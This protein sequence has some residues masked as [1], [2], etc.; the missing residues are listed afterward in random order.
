M[1]TY[2]YNA[3]NA[4]TASPST[5]RASRRPAGNLPD[6]GVVRRVIGNV[7]VASGGLRVLS[8]TR[9]PRAAPRLE[10]ASS[11]TKSGGP[12]AGEGSARNRRAGRSRRDRAPR[13]TA[14]G[15]KAPIPSDSPKRSRT[16]V[17]GLRCPALEGDAV[18]HSPGR[19]PQQHRLTSGGV[20]RT[21]ARG[22]F[23]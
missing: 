13:P 12:E 7:G 9:G 4:I 1:P 2:L 18:G 3:P 20:R 11:E 8:R 22:R 19:N 10:V 21:E 17:F 23:C 15:S 14:S 6:C 5:R 16:R